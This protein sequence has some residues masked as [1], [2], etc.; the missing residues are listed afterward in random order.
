MNFHS[1]Q[2]HFASIY[3]KVYVCIP[4]ARIAKERPRKSDKIRQK[5]IVRDDHKLS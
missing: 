3:A 1:L 5:Y 4:Q 2:N